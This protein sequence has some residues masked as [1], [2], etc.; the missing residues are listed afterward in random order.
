[1]PTLAEPW[2]GACNSCVNWGER[3]RA[4]RLGGA[5]ILAALWRLAGALVLRSCPT[6]LG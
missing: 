5:F 2:Q 1:M 3:G 4:A 6:K